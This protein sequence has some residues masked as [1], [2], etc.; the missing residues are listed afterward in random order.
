V[1]VIYQFTVSYCCTATHN[2]NTIVS[3][4]NTVEPRYLELRYFECM[5]NFLSVSVYVGICILNHLG[6]SKFRYVESFFWSVVTSRYRGFTVYHKITPTSIY[7]MAMKY[8]YTCLYTTTC[9][10]IFL[11]TNIIIL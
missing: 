7:E 9:C 6:N 5:W 11:N 8:I 3:I 1:Y 10:Y 2:R 4:F